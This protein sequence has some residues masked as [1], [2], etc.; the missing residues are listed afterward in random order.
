MLCALV[1]GWSMGLGIMVIVC[2]GP[3]QALHF[4]SHGCRVHP[5]LG[6]C[7]A[8]AVSRAS[9]ASFCEGVVAIG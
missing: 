8:V 9:V 3:T 5:S 4:P 6:V 7:V 1:A 2:G